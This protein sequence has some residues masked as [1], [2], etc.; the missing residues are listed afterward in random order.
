[1]PYSCR[2]QSWERIKFKKTTKKVK[3]ERWGVGNERKMCPPI[4]GTYSGVISPGAEERDDCAR[5][6]QRLDDG[7]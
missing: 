5:C 1:M 3:I 6:L 2:Q 4:C 7:H